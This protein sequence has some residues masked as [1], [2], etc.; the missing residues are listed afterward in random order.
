MDLV[1][2]A[3]ADLSKWAGGLSSEGARER[4]G[5]VRVPVR[6]SHGLLVVLTV[7]TG[8]AGQDDEPSRRVESNVR[9]SLGIE[10]AEVTGPAWRVGGAWRVGEPAR[11]SLGPSSP[12][13]SNAADVIFERVQGVATLSDGS[14]VVADAGPATVSVFSSRGALQGRFGGRGEGPGELVGISSLF[15]C[16]DLIG[17]VDP[18]QRVHVVQNDGTYLRQ[19][20]SGGGTVEGLSSDYFPEESFGLFDSRLDDPPVPTEEW[21]VFDSSGAWVSTL[22]M[23][24]RF[25]LHAVRGGMV[26][27]VAQDDLMVESVQA[28]VLGRHGPTTSW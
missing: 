20:Q 25:E 24:P 17:V 11:L 16:G 3:G 9:D 6:A 21:T 19:L 1:T 2:R 5:K 13:A 14:V 15:T 8:C 27:G 7:V 28:F 10:I 23:P 12:Q 26:Y 4:S 22:R 18:R